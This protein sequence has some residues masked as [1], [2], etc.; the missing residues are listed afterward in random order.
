MAYAAVKPKILILGELSDNE[1]NRRSSVD[2][3]DTEPLYTDSDG[4][5]HTTP[6]D[7][8][9]SRSSSTYS[10]DTSSRGSFKSQYPKKGTTAIPAHLVSIQPVIDLGYPFA[11]E[12]DTV[13]L[14]KALDGPR[15][16]NLLRLSEEYKHIRANIVGSAD[17]VSDPGISPSPAIDPLPFFYW[18]V[19]T[20]NDNNNSTN[21]EV[22]LVEVLVKLD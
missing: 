4:S 21:T 18:K 5:H 12:G 8:D 16:D 3:L 14:Q 1:Q 13:K 20:N 19:E 11:I 22:M 15:I 9:S 6:Y 7:Y 10:S 17:T 2:S